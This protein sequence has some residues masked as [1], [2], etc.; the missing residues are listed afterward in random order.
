[1]F[2]GWCSVEVQVSQ[3]SLNSTAAYF[4]CGRDGLDSGEL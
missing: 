2:E 3:V 4:L 1:M